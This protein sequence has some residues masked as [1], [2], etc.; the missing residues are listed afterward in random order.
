MNLLDII[1]SMVMG[2]CLVRGAFRGIVKELSSIVGV[3][4]GFYA[5][6]SYYPMFARL[7]SGLVSSSA[8]LNVLSFF[9]VFVIGFF[10]VSFLGVVLK[11]VIRVAS[12]GWADRVAGGLFAG[13][14]GVLILSI[15]IICLA[16]FLPSN[17]PIIQKSL[18]TP[19]VLTVSEKV[20]RLVPDKMGKTFRINVV[21][22]KKS[23]KR[24]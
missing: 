6:Y 20:V 2:Y 15:I 10:S 3:F 7:L 23:W 11:H 24:T 21:A 17:A 4:A 19:Y 18:L 8:T 1:I 13:L 12:F 9:L 14:K 5:A 16:T 22:L